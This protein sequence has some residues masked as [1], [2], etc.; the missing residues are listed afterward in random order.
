MTQIQR[1]RRSRSPRLAN[2][3]LLAAVTSAAAIAGCSS[4]IDRETADPGSA[5]YSDSLVARAIL[6]GSYGAGAAQTFT[7]AQGVREY[8][9]VDAPGP[10]ASDT[11]V[12]PATTT[13]PA[14][15]NAADITIPATRPDSAGAAPANSVDNSNMPTYIP[16]T[17][18]NDIGLSAVT[19]HQPENVF[20]LSL[21]DAIHRALR[22]ALDIKVQS[23]SPGI[24]ESKIIQQEAAF[25]P[26]FFANSNWTNTNEPAGSFVANPGNTANNTLPPVFQLGRS[27]QDGTLWSNDVGVRKLLSS[28][29]NVSVS[30]GFTYRDLN[31]SAGTGFPNGQTVAPNINA[32]IEQPLLRGFG[33]NVTEANIY[34]AQRDQRI[35]LEQFRRQV[36]TTIDTVEEDYHNLVLARTNVAIGEQL[37]VATEDTEKRVSER[38]IVDADQISI[39]QARAAVE[40]RRAELV[41]FRIDLRAASDK[42]KQDLNDPE[43]NVSD[44]ALIDPSDRPIAEPIVFNVADAIETALRQRTELQEDRLKLEQSDITLTVARNDLLPRLDLTASVQANGLNNEWDQAFASTVAPNQYIDYSAGIRLEF[45]LGNRQAEAEVRQRQLERNQL[46]TQTVADAQRIVIEVKKQLRELLGSYQ[47]LTVRE[48]ARIL[49]AQELQAITRK[50]EIVALTPEF[51]QLKLDSQGRLAA[52]EQALIQAIVNYN[53]ALVRF[54]VAKGTLLEFDRVSLNRAPIYHPEDDNNKLR[55]MGKTYNFTK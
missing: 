19:L 21:Q 24:N 43:I 7:V 6:Q 34:I 38:A 22:N 4:A 25:D 30:A 23:Y 5:R 47:E 35:S 55:F 44:N 33:S 29:A 17:Q 53:L 39:S 28:G 46:L 26:V 8:P 42:L 14:S 9:R 52:A 49:A 12:V 45:P 10:G 51:L 13:A 18:A 16:T 11:A 40:Q 3:L 41:R 32:T 50:E 37:L 1:S 20:H 48:T 54:E 36:I 15:P 31:N 2:A 27:F